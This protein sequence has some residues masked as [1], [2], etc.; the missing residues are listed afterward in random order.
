M[1][2]DPASCDDLG[3]AHRLSGGFQVAGLSRG[4]EGGS[5][6]GEF[7]AQGLMVESETIIEVAE[8]DSSGD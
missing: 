6:S 5:G 8:D 1:G 4:G 3:V 7:L 2:R